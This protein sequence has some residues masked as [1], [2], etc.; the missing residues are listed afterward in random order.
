MEP[1]LSVQLTIS[2]DM[3]EAGF[4]FRERVW[5]LDMYKSLTNS[6][7]SKIGLPNMGSKNL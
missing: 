5:L 3:E 1:P 2:S 6:E 4:L 7:P